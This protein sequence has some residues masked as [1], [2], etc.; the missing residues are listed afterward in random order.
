MGFLDLARH[1]LA[2]D[3]ATNSYV[4]PLASVKPREALPRDAVTAH[5]LWLS[6]LQILMRPQCG[7]LGSDTP[8]IPVCTPFCNVTLPLLPSSGRMN[9]SSGLGLWLALTNVTLVEATLCDI[10]MRWDLKK[11]T[12]S[13]FIPLEYCPETTGSQ[14]SLK[15]E[16]RLSTG[17]PR[18]PS[19]QPAPT[20][21]QAR[22]TWGP[23]NSAHPKCSSKSSPRWN[24]QKNCLAN[25][26]NC[27]NAPHSG[28]VFYC[29]NS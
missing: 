8:P 5:V 17:E 10:L 20:A 3:T 6:H 26:Q 15:E 19:W 23:S 22:E 13:K 27:F 12:A 25:P 18:G 11:S 21:S 24:Q 29:I 9:F 2:M 14:S 4:T 16:E 1:Y 7:I 28:V